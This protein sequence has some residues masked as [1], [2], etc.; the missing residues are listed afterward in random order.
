MTTVTAIY[1]RDDPILLAL[2]PQSLLDEYSRLR[3]VTRSALLKWNIEA[4][5]VSDITS[6]WAHECGGSR[7]LIAVPIRQRY[8]GHA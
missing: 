1:H 8:P 6:V 3:A 7:M 4:V 5:G 2:A